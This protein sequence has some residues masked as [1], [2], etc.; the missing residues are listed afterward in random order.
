M[1]AA[2][3][4]TVCQLLTFTHIKSDVGVLTNNRFPLKQGNSLTVVITSMF[5]YSLVININDVI[6]FVQIKLTNKRFACVRILKSKQYKHLKI[7][8]TN[9]IRNGNT[10]C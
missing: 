7:K 2:E 1:L 8:K 9:I 5:W 4:V 6:Y 10:L 3:T